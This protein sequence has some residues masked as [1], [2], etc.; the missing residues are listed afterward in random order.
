M[1]ENIPNTPDPLELMWGKDMV[2]PFTDQDVATIV[3]SFRQ[4]QAFINP[5]SKK[6]KDQFLSDEELRLIFQNL[7]EETPGK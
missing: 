5:Q 4:E 3:A 1:N 6:A 7:N 2:R